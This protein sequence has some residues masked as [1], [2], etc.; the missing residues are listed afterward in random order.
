MALAPANFC[1]AS[2]DSTTDIL[3]SVSRLLVGLRKQE[4]RH[5]QLKLTNTVKKRTSLSDPIWSKES[6]KSSSA[7]YHQGSPLPTSGQPALDDH[8][9]CI[10]LRDTIGKVP[11][12]LSLKALFLGL[13]HARYLLQHKTPVITQQH[14]SP[15]LPDPSLCP[16]HKKGTVA[17]AGALPLWNWPNTGSGHLRFL[18]FVHTPWRVCFPSW[19]KCIFEWEGIIFVPRY[20]K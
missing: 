9:G 11:K 18:L 12:P 15:Q 7:S 2:L 20:Q 4:R 10:K 8:K 17:V 19:A 3:F 14:L 1:R 13:V 6:N 16:T 5:P